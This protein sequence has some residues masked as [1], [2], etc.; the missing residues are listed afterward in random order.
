MNIN[1]FP[2]RLT[3]FF[4]STFRSACWLILIIILQTSLVFADSDDDHDGISDAYENELLQK[5]AP[6]IWLHSNENRWPVSVP[7]FLYRVTMRY[8]HKNCSD[9]KIISTGSVTSQNIVAGR[10]KN[11]NWL[12]RHSGRVNKSDS[13]EAKPQ[14]SFFLQF[15]NDRHHNGTTDRKEWRLYGHVYKAGRQ[16]VIQ[17]WQLYA[18]NDSAGPINH[19]GDWEASGVVIDENENPVKVF[20]YRH[21]HIRDFAPDRIEWEGLHHVTYSAKGSHGQYRGVQDSNSAVPGSCNADS[22][23]DEAQGISDNCNRGTAWN[24]W[25]AEFGGIVNVGELENP[26]NSNNWI[27]YSGLW[28]E[29]GSASSVGIKYTSGPPGPAYGGNRK[30]WNWL[31]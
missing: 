18:F 27:R 12:C 20:F 2:V 9:C 8:S 22:F 31:R 17:Y 10:H 6:K 5:F 30:V 29:I 25:E 3:N 16:T 23:P 1:K 15:P 26:L 14:N 28:G 21:G 19:E 24:S 4:A 7:W 11:K 13:Y